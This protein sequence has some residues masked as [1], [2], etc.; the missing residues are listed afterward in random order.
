VWPPHRARRGGGRGSRAGPD[1]KKNH[2]YTTGIAGKASRVSYGKRKVD[3]EYLSGADMTVIVYAQHN[4]SGVPGATITKY[5]QP[6]EGESICADGSV[7][8][9]ACKG[10]VKSVNGCY[11]VRTGVGKQ[12]I[13]SCG[14]AYATAK[15]R[16]DQAGDSGGPVLV[17]ATQKKLPHLIATLKGIIKAGNKSGTELLF[18][19]MNSLKSV[20]AGHPTTY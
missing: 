3:A 15:T 4:V 10:T 17:L 19:N 9:L 11:R 13:V 12:T 1:A 7:T 16:L 6:V 18:T 8:Y 2:I 20:L 5:S 14:L